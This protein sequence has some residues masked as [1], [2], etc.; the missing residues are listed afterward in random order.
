MRNKIP[1]AKKQAAVKK[2]GSLRPLIDDYIDSLKDWKK[3]IALELRQIIRASS[4][5]LTEEVKWG[6]PCYTA[7]G[8]CVCGR[9]YV[10][11]D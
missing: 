10:A 8:K 1:L 7:G 6:F 2:Q 11:F 5:E 3:E 4:R 9:S